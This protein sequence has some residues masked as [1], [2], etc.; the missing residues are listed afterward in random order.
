M[1]FT[2]RAR[3]A[4]TVLLVFQFILHAPAY[5]QN[6]PTGAAPP[7]ETGFWNQ[8][9]LTGNWGGIRSRMKDKGV[10]LKFELNQFYQGVASG[11]VET[12]SEY[13]GKFDTNFKFDFGKLAGW[14]FWSAEIKAET[15]FGGPL[16]TST[17]TI[18]PVNTAAIVPGGPRRLATATS[19][20]VM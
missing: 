13:N 3:I 12:G 5:C 4:A 1:N 8:E 7:P 16:V 17:G 9:T 2:G 10:E 20:S 15:R 18:S 19:G 14:Q 6:P 11:G